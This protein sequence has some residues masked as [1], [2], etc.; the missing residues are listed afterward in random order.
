MT[1][2]YKKFPFQG[3][4][5]GS[6]ST[7]ENVRDVGKE[8]TSSDRGSSGS[9]QRSHSDMNEMEQRAKTRTEREPPSRSLEGTP[10]PL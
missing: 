7:S 10:G 5:G 4:G 8:T 3:G 9:W 2:S 1:W 6:S